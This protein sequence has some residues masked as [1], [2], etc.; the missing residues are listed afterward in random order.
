MACVISNEKPAI[1]M[2]LGE[3]EASV[4]TSKRKADWEE[5]ADIC[6]SSAQKSGMTYAQAQR[7]L[8][9]VRK[10]VDAGDR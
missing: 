3:T 8:K 1:L 9:Q 5:L 10:L 4:R 2:G 7:T 6:Y